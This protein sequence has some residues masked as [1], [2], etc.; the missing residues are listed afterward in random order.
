MFRVILCCVLC[1]AMT[2]SA[3]VL[4]S[5]THDDLQGDYSQTSQIVISDGALAIQSFVQGAEFLTIF[6]QKQSFASV[7]NTSLKTFVRISAEQVV[8]FQ[9]MIANAAEQT[10]AKLKAEIAALP[11]E[12]R[13]QVDAL[14]NESDAGREASFSFRAVAP[15]RF[16][17][18]ENSKEVGAWTCKV[19][20][21]YHGDTQVVELCVVP[22]STLG[23]SAADFAVIDD[24]QRQYAGIA[25]G[26]DNALSAYTLWQKKFTQEVQGVPVSVVQYANGSPSLETTL[27]SVTPRTI[28]KS[29]FAL[30]ET[31]L[32]KKIADFL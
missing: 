9:A 14:L 8:T 31:Y 6:E 5:A 24:L 21:G 12:Q 18:A 29:T 7:V 11:E 13:A 15:T 25:D 32:E 27:V 22:S 16:V 1:S 4:I 10:K 30:P 20:F 26:I 17:D 28:D 19:W 3:G 23:I 2:A